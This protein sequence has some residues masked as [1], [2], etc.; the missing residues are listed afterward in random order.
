LY[1]SSIVSRSSPCPGA[2]I[3]VT[4]Y[5]ERPIPAETILADYQP[6]ERAPRPERT[7]R[8]DGE[9]RAPRQRRERKPR[10]DREPREPT[11]LDR[12]VFMAAFPEGYT[13]REVGAW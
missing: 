4:P 3:R 1:S 8:A 5:K 13:T 10:A 7:P 11:P 9:E 6:A 12:R 2:N